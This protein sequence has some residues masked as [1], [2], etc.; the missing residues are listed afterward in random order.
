MTPYVLSPRFGVPFVD[1]SLIRDRVISEGRKMMRRKRG[2]VC[3]C[4]RERERELK[5][6]D[7]EREGEST[8]V[9]CDCVLCT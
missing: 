1:E 9:R 5:V 4:E 2:C 7:N 8:I 6:N 3:V